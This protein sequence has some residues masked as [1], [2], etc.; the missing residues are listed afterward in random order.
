[1]TKL[2]KIFSLI[3]V[4]A[5]TRWRCFFCEDLLNKEP[6]VHI[7]VVD[8]LSWEEQLYVLQEQSYC[9]M[10]R[11]LLSLQH[12]LHLVLQPPEALWGHLLRLA[13]DPQP[14]LTQYSLHGA[15]PDQ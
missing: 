15:A 1:M 3:T 12:D 11:Q 7:P 4:T 10:D 14:S 5:A 8:H 6:L 9:W 13:V 2:L